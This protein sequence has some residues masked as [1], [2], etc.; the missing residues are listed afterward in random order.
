MAK[1]I[2]KVTK[3]GK[4]PLANPALNEA[5]LIAADK[6]L[7]GIRRGENA[8]IT[9]FKEHVGARVGEAIHT[10]G[11][12]FIFAFSQLTALEVDNRWEAA[13]RTWSQ[14]IEAQ[15]VSSFEAPKVY[16]INPEVQG[17]SRP[18]TEPGKPGNVPPIVPEGSVYPHFIFTGQMAQAGAIH[19]RGG[20]Y[21][22]TFEKIVSDVAGIVPEIPRLITEA[23]LEGEEWDAWSGILAMFSNSALHLQAGTTLDGRPFATDAPLS[24]EALAG[25]LYQARNRTVAG[26]KVDVS[27]YVLVVPMGE[28]DT[29]EFYLNQGRI[30]G[31][32]DPSTGL[33]ISYLGYNPLAGIRGVVESRYFSGTQWALLPAPGAI[34]GS[35]RFYNLGRLRGHEGPEVRLNNATGIYLGGGA[36]PPFEGSFETDS[37]AF[38]GRI[39]CG[40]LEWNDN[41]AVL[42]SGDGVLPSV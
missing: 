40:G 5:K 16:S 18:A 33:E 35:D 25:A 30:V 21:D 34:R 15:T 17:F 2:E 19:K 23:L 39:I 29:A 8:A 24:R 20:R 9:A 27:S 22:L 4:L 1:I 37:A 31:Q 3:G 36:V 13:E 11:D 26:R 41:F 28:R 6:I 10:T 42:S 38:R 7:Q 32:T 14:A 12:D